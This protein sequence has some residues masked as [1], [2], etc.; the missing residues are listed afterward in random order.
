MSRSSTLSWQMY[1]VTALIALT[2]GGIGGRLTPPVPRARAEGILWAAPGYGIEMPARQEEGQ[3][4]QTQQVPKLGFIRSDII[5]SMHPGVPG[6]RA[7]I[8]EQLRAW[9]RQQE[10]M[11]ARAEAL[12]NELRTAQLSPVRRRTRQEELQQTID[13]L[14]QFQTQMW[15]SGGLA[16]QKEQELMQPIF[17][18][19]DAVIRDIAEGQ[20]FHL[21]FDASAGGLLFGHLDMD[22]TRQAMDKLGIEPPAE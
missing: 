3:P 13:E 20:G 6:I 16:E 2:A 1:A 21:I 12:Q 22:L 9:Q 18:E 8:E 4:A 17:D 19:I 5:L 14:N 7:S 15:S 10:D 11:Q